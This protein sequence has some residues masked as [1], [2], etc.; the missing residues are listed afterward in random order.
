MTDSKKNAA[1][2]VLRLF[3]AQAQEVRQAAAAFPQEWR[4]TAQCM[5]RG[6][7][8]LVALRAAGPQNLDKGERSLR[9]CFPNDLYGEGETDLAAAT[10]QALEANDRLLVCSDPAAGALAEARLEAVEGAEKVFDFG[11]QSYT[12]PKNGPKIEELARRS[13]DKNGGAL[14]RVQA[15]VRVVGADLS[16]GCVEQ[17]DRVLLLVGDRKGCW[18]RA[19]RPEDNPG[20]WLLDMV[21]RAACRLEQAEGAR[22]QRYGAPVDGEAL[23]LPPLEPP[24][25]A[26][27]EPEPEPE[28][29][30]EGEPWTV[31]PS[32]PVEEAA[33]PAA[34]AVRP[35]RRIAGRLLAA[36][37]LL[38]LAG[39]GA[40]WY[41]TGGNLAALPE[42][43]GMQESN[44]SGA[45]LMQIGVALFP[46]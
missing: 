21:R 1:V 2:R 17:E 13:A 28:P 15:A 30:A 8:T 5:S 44:H 9:A 18:V 36:V 22:W 20:L 42:L 46:R 27:P 25:S 33:P 41:F 39:L 4:L 19:V 6:G 43:L 7:E 35:R 24:V 12:H 40:A 38:A 26:P 34:E 29:K 23:P 31:Q 10:V 11:S 14:A 37:L 32:A 45:S 3:G 16:A